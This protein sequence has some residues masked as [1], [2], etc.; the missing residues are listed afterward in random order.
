M[1]NQ[2][3]NEEEGGVLLPRDAG[4]GERRPRREFFGALFVLAVAL[5]FVVQALGMPFKDASWEWYTAPNIFPLGMAAG[6]GLCALFVALRGWFEWRARAD[7][8]PPLRLIDSARAW[9]MPRFL[10][11]GVLI[12]VLIFFLG[13]IDFY[14]LAPLSIMTFGLLFKSDPF[15]KALKSSVI[16]AVFIVVFLLTISKVF[17]IVFP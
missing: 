7:S 17:G 1:Q 9:G 4:G 14:F 8:L 13:K 10:G 16:A 5:A 12:G 6:L 15:R 2:H 3:A 11:G